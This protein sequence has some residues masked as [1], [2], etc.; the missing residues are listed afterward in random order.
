MIRVTIHN[1]C[2][3]LNEESREEKAAKNL[4]ADLEREF[5]QKKNANGQIFIMT[6]VTYGGGQ[7]SE[8]DMLLLC[9]LGGMPFEIKKDG[10]E[11]ATVNVGKV[12]FVL[13]LKNHSSFTLKGDQ[14]IVDYDGVPHNASSQSRQQKFD[15]G[16]YLVKKLGECP[17][18]Y[19]Y[20]WFTSM[21]SQSVD[22]C[23]GRDLGSD[24]SCD[25]KTLSS[26]FSL[27]EL[28]QKTIVVWPKSVWWENNGLL[29]KMDSFSKKRT[30][31]LKDI[32]EHLTTVKVVAG[33]L[34]R[35]KLNLLTMI[36]ARDRIENLTIDTFTEFSGRA[37][38]GKTIK[39]IQRAIQL[40]NRDKG[41]RCLLLTYNRAL[42]NDINRL[43]FFAGERQRPGEKTVS[44]NT[45]HSFFLDL[46]VLFDVRE[47]K[48]I[49]INTYFKRNGEYEKDL[50]RLL[51]DVIP[52]Y[53]LGGFN[54][55]K[56]IEKKIDWDYIF[57]D[58]AQDWLKVEKEILFK[59]YG[60]QHII[61]ADGIDQF[62]RYGEHLD[63]SEGVELKTQVV[64]SVSLR[65]KNNLSAF[66]NAFAERVGVEWN[67]TPNRNIQGGDVYILD[68]YYIN[69]HKT[70]LKKCANDYAEPYDVLFLVPWQNTK[71]GSFDL[72]ETFRTKGII[73]FDGTNTENRTKYPII[74]QECRLYNY[75]SCRGLEGWSVIC[76]KF[77]LM[78]QD[79]IDEFTRQIENG[80]ITL[81]QG[82]SKKEFARESAFL[83]ALMPLTRAIDKL[84]I[85][86]NDPNSEISKVLLEIHDSKNYKDFVH[87]AIK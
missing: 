63:W 38:T 46:L 76:Y 84:V 61:V 13:E 80:D 74:D 15:F 85:T 86:L 50:N 23:F 32:V 72:Y 6:N 67:V 20:L 47:N 82:V 24:L 60:P 14:V 56:E 37:G 33:G 7:T 17:Y 62:M 18:F 30:T 59:V 78:V 71:N 16:E 9:D 68:S 31:L 41:N 26:H 79:K 55:L 53:D 25:D 29:G 3:N 36:E 34:T 40:K 19:N 43:L 51:E 39:L 44:A 11:K 65:Q 42:V 28:I 12:A 49:N 75:E 27:N 66:V 22:K 81:P 58:E 5:A 45:L 57:I 64:D 8:I 10:R 69:F 77:D 4:K 52:T 73:V 35:K 83:W 1:I 48:E 21:S 2:H 70:L 87:L 54:S